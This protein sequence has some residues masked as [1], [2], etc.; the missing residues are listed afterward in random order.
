MKTPR[1]NGKMKR[2][3]QITRTVV[4]GIIVN[5]VVDPRD[6]TRPRPGNDF[7]GRKNSHRLHKFINEKIFRRNLGGVVEMKK[8]RDA[9][10]VKMKERFIPA[11]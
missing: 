10:F 7:K 6:G 8:P 4:A 2:H 9:V 3:C 11:L 5:A 1:T